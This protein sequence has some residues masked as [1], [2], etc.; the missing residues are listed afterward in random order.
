MGD[1][2]RL[3]DLG[4]DRS[5]DPFVV[6][7]LVDGRDVLRRADERERDQVDAVRQGPAQVFEVLVGDRRH[8]HHGTGQVDALGV[9]KGAAL[10]D[11]VS[12]RPGRSPPRPCS[13]TRPSSTRIG[14]PTAT[15]SDSPVWV[16][17]TDSWSP[18][19]RSA[20]ITNRAPGRSRTD[21]PANRPSRILG[22]C[23][24][25]RTPTA[26]P[27]ASAAW[28]TSATERAW[29]AWRAVAQVDARHVEAGLDQR[30]HRAQG[31]GRRTERGDDLGAAHGETLPI[32]R[33]PIGRWLLPQGRCFS[34]R[35]SILLRGG[36]LDGPLR[37]IAVSQ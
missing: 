29:S 28:R 6:H 23:R 31:A 22:P 24:S 36:L 3:L 25:A 30:R 10:D 7:D 26:R 14:S 27:L 32:G 16:V 20:V 15:S 37:V 13:S 11:P 34:N 12:P 33:T 1:G 4:D 19:P 35:C 17:D 5:V 21:P 9:R 8:A 18:G 2:L